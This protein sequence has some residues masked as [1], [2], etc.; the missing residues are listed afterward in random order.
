MLTCHQNALLDHLDFVRHALREVGVEAETPYLFAPPFELPDSGPTLTSFFAAADMGVTRL[1]SYAGQEVALLD[2]MRNPRAKTTKTYA[3]LVI[4]ARAAQYIH[5]A[6]EPITIVTPSSANKG[7]ALRDAVLRAYETGLVRPDQLTITT[8]V[9]ASSQPKLWSSAL[10]DD[11]YLRHANPVSVLSVEQPVSRVKEIVHELVVKRAQEFHAATGR[12]LWHTLS[13]DNYRAADAVRARVERD[14]SISA[15]KRVHIHA[16]SSAFGLLGHHFGR[17]LLIRR[18]EEVSATPP[19]YLLVQHLARPD[20][21]LHLYHGTF[22]GGHTPLYER[23]PDGLY[24]QQQDPH[25][26]MVTEDTHE[27]LDSTFYT[28]QPATSPAMDAIIAAQGGAGVVVSHQECIQRYTEIA[29]L[30]GQAG[31]ALPQDPSRLREWSL[32]M[33]MTGMMAALDRGLLPSCDDILVHGS[34]CYSQ[35]DYTPIPVESLVPVTDAE[36]LWNVVL[37]A[38]EETSRGA[39]ARPAR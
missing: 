14:L 23:G 3:S 31:I 4:V 7:T 18:G 34:G 10:N 5:E 12:R 38:A 32:V 26:P 8:I 24:R 29:C 19:A 2:L 37:R 9:P 33:A 39:V 25:F 36:G 20:M 16:V 13:L 6:G 11:A 30:L 1:G 21:V 27:M 22:S 35:D 28:A 17:M 15:G